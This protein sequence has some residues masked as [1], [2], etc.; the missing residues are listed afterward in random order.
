MKII[1]KVYTICYGYLDCDNSYICTNEVSFLLDGEYNKKLNEILLS[2]VNNFCQKGY[3]V[4]CYWDEE[5]L[6]DKEL[7]EIEEYHSM[8][9]PTK[10]TMIQEFLIKNYKEEEE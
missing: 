10:A 6:T 3:W 4:E 2:S 9:E 7:Q 1:K 5:E 8:T